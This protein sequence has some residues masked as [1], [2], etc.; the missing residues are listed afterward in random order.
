MIPGALCVL[1]TVAYHVYNDNQDANVRPPLWP[2]LLASAAFFY[3]W[4]LAILIFDLVFVWHRYIRGAVSQKYLT[5]LRRKAKGT[6]GPAVGPPNDGKEQSGG[7]I[8]VEI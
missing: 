2:L 8:L 6:G 1:G 3:L 4:W 7:N 5:K